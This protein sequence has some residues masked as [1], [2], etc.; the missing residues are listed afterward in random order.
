MAELTNI[1]L[2]EQMRERQNEAIAI[3]NRLVG[4]RSFE[5][6]SHFSCPHCRKWFSISGAPTFKIEWACPWCFEVSNYE[7]EES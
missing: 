2:A 3:A 6:L 7:A 5:T 4:K 1:E